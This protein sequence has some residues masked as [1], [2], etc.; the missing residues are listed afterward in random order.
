MNQRVIRGIRDRIPGGKLIGRMSGAGT[1]TPGLVDINSLAQQL[2]TTGIVGGSGG[3][4]AAGSTP[5]GVG[6]AL[7]SNVTT[8]SAVSLTS[9][10]AADVTTLALTTGT[11]IIS[12]IVHFNMVGATGT[13]WISAVTK[14]TATLPT[15]SLDQPFTT[16]NN[17]GGLTNAQQ[18][19]TGVG[20]I[21][22][23]GTQN[24]FLEAQLT[25]TGG[26]PTAYGNIIAF[27]IA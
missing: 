11:W 5:T 18:L 3:T 10:T 20:L 13:S 6:N 19:T 22:V 1:A 21:V 26:A 8:G 9:A 12:G 25:Y 27:R 17:G 16:M 23:S 7:T 15:L 14:T 2:V 24:V 4:A